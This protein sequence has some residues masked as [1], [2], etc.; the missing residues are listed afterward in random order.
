MYARSLTVPD[1]SFFLFGPR[2]T[3][4]TT[5]LRHELPDA[6]WFNLLLN[7]E[8][9]PLMESTESF[10]FAVEAL[11]PGSWVV[12][13]EVQKLPELLNEI[14]DLISIHGD[15]YRFALSGPV[16]ANSNDSIAICWQAEYSSG[17]FFR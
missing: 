6:L 15:C 8:L 1:H 12:V 16:P 14:H 10:R 13:D 11:E 3:G 9:L 17:N 7:R 5:W 2:G 4:K